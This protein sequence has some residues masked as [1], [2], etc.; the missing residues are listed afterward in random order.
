[1]SVDPPFLRT[2]APLLRGL[3]KR[4]RNW[5]DA[6]LLYPVD[7]LQR[8]TV[9]GLADDLNR[10]SEALDVE[11]PI[12]VV[13]LMGGTGVGKSTLLN[14]LAGASVAQA[15]FTRPTTRDPVVSFPPSLHANMLDPALRLCRLVRHDRA[16]LMHKILVDTPDVDSNDTAN[17]EKLIQLLPI[18]DVVLYVGSQEK[19]HD[20]IG[21]EL[22]KEQRLRR[23]FAFVMNKWDRCTHVG[24]TGLRPDEDLLR[25]LRAEG[26]TNPR[27]FRTNAQQWVDANG[28][29]PSELPPGEQFQELRRWLEL[30]LTRLEIDAVKIRGVG[31]LLDHVNAAAT[32]VRPPDL[33]AESTTVNESWQKLLDRESQDNAEV[34]TQTLDPKQT[35]LEQQFSLRANQRFRGIMAGYLRFTTMVRSIGRPFRERFLGGSNEPVDLAITQF[36]SGCAEVAS[37]RALKERGTAL[38][39]RLLVDANQHGLPMAIL[40]E[41]TQ[42]VQKLDWQEKYTRALVDA[43]TDVEKEYTSPSGWRAVVRGGVS[44]LANILPEALLFGSIVILLWQWSVGRTLPTIAHMLMPLYVVVATLV[45]LHVLIGFVFPVRWSSI[46]DRFRECL[47]QR[48]NHEYEQTYLMLPAAAASE[49]ASE[50]VRVDEIAKETHD[51]IAWVHARESAASVGELYGSR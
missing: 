46:R 50:R 15:S 8:A 37:E 18:A 4:L 16:E 36:A 23:A 51:V 43:L 13:M 31:Q 27:L 6:K 11:Q 20:Q 45:L 1:M 2:L 10:Q 12:L 32:S 5:L 41:R 39:N 19:Y 47:M 44:V 29:V 21:W 28:E 9:E 14:A 49:V 35:D 30:G 17:R 40:S 7:T 42:A 33:A 3:E 22:F 26:F 24:A 48:L 34:L 25:D 38:T